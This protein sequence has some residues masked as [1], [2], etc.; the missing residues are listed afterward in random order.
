MT[1]VFEPATRERKREAIPLVHFSFEREY[2]AHETFDVSVIGKGD[3]V[4]FVY[5][6]RGW[7]N[8][9]SSVRVFTECVTEWSTRP[10]ADIYRTGYAL[11]NGFNVRVTPVQ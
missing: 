9:I 10:V 4:P 7:S 11:V 6:V 2:R 3:D 5:T 8:M 1:V